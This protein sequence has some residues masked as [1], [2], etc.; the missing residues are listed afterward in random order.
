M[1]HQLFESDKHG[2][3]IMNWSCE[4][5]APHMKYF[6]LFVDH[7]SILMTWTL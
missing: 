2:T 6:T 7:S 3:V 1:Q 4:Y 5:W